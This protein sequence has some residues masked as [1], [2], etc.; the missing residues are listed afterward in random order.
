LSDLEKVKKIYKYI[1]QNIAYSSVSFRQ[2]GIVPQNPATVINTRIGD[3]KDVSTLFVSMCKEAGINA[4]LVLV[5]TRDNGQNTLL[6][7]SIDF[8][9]CIAKTNINGKDYYLEL[10]SNSL[11][12]GSFFNSDLN[13]PILNINNT[14]NLLKK[15]NPTNRG[16]NQMSY[17]TSIKINDKNMAINSTN[18]NT[19]SAVSYLR[20]DFNNLS[21][22]D[23]VKK[24][25]EQL[26]NQFPDNEVSFLS[27]VNLDP[28][29]SLSDTLSTKCSYSLLNICKPVAGMSIFSLPWSAAVSPSSL[30][31]AEPRHFGID[32]TQLFY[33]DKNN[34]QIDLELPLG[35]KLI[36][37]IKPLLIDNEYFKYSLISKSVNNKVIINRDFILKKDFVAKDKVVEFYTLFKKMAE[38]DQQQLAFK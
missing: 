3:C 28:K 29:I 17:K 18:F 11:P 31:I 1:T 2:S 30:T 10:T 37:P 23:Q 12:F 32:L 25:K 33:A 35:K 6:L 36:E 21:S 26:S 13:S 20:N 38:S 22:K 14:T 15:L 4:E 7:P 8:N 34:E 16:L 5:K 27:F 19:G 24:M 9:H